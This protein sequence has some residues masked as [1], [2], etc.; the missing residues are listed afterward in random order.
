MGKPFLLPGESLGFSL[1]LPNMGIPFRPFHVMFW[2]LV[3]QFCH[4]DVSS[5]LNS[6]VS[7]SYARPQD[8]SHCR[9]A[10]TSK[11]I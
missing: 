5:G 2:F 9:S 7:Q 8:K 10:N 1:L 3:G 6:K 4:F 11:L